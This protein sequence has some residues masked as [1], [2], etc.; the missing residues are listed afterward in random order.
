MNIDQYLDNTAP[1]E[2]YEELGILRFARDFLPPCKGN[3]ISPM[4]YK[5]M[6]SALDLYNPKRLYRP[7]RQVY[8]LVHREGAKTTYFS[9]VFPLYVICTTGLPILCL[10]EDEN[11]IEKPHIV[12]HEKEFILIAS[13]TS[14]AAERM[15]SN[16]RSE[17]SVN[18]S[19]CYTFGDL[20]PRSL[21]DDPF[22]DQV[23][24]RTMFRLTNDCMVVGLGAGQQIRGINVGM[25]PTLLIADDIY[26]QRGVLTEE[27]REKTREWWSKEAVNTVDSQAGKIIMVGTIVHQDTVTVDVTN[28]SS[29]Y[30]FSYPVINSAELS[31]AL[32]HCVVDYDR[33]RMELP[34]ITTIND[35]QSKFRSLSWGDRHT[36]H[37]ILSMY[38]QSF[39]DG[40]L[41]HFYQEYLH[42]L[43]A[44][45][46]ISFTDDL[47]TFANIEYDFSLGH[48]W[49]TFEYDN[50]T[51]KGLFQGA[52]GVD[53]AAGETQSSDNTAIMV[54]GYVHAYPIIQ[55]YDA[56]AAQNVHPD[57]KY[58]VTFPVMLDGYANKMEIYDQQKQ[59]GSI[60]VTKKGIVNEIERLSR[61]YRI[62]RVVVEC[63]ATQALLARE[64]R[65]YFND[66]KKEAL[67]K[68]SYFPNITVIEK[69][70]TTQMKKEERIKHALLPVMQSAR[71]TILNR[72]S[73]AVIDAWGQLGVLGRGAHDDEADGIA[74]AIPEARKPLKIDYQAIGTQQEKIL[75]DRAVKY[76]AHNQD[77]LTST[78]D[79]EVV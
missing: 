49:L 62:E 39:E 15:T 11:G 29:W 66:K 63:S 37:Y 27:T 44:P 9:Y 53:I 70:P 26:S 42:I 17:L 56:M 65:R 76:P 79:W 52:I 55:G 18:R 10:F 34:P 2:E 28:N 7:H 8:N 6:K 25:R 64:V 75:S 77:V 4:H 58:G 32:S 5:M 57:K 3:R 13:E 68:K 45:D 69:V 35:L 38:K 20:T 21:P 48:S 14:T 24:R 31:E 43:Q 46:D 51:W 12:E 54:G 33:K 72:E 61:K 22:L 16:I 36:L 60:Q 30:G 1:I 59:L 41:S 47:V 23:W 78:I 67:Q 50:N 73:K 40:R 19:L 74:Y 71:K